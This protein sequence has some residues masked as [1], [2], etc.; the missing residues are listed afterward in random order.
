[1]TR[2]SIDP[3]YLLSILDE[4][5]IIPSPTGYTDTVVRFTTREKRLGLDW[6]QFRIPL[7]PDAPEFHQRRT[8]QIGATSTWLL[9][10]ATG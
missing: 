1:M 8:P 4:L 10:S 7:T 5:L 9:A 3:E 2:L 6:V